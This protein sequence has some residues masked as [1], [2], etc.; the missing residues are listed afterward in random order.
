MVQTV[1]HS[2]RLRNLL[3][4]APVH[5]VLSVSAFFICFPLIWM[6]LTSLKPIEQVFLYPPQVFPK[7]VMWRNYVDA[8]TYRPFHLFFRNTM[9]IEVAVVI[10][11]LLSNSLVAYGFARLRFPGREALFTIVLSTMMLPAVVQL[12]P[13]FIVFSKLGWVNTYYPLTVPAFFGTPFFIFLLRQF[14]RG[15]PEELRDAAKI[16]GCSELGIWWRIMVPL[17]KHA[18]AVVAIFA[19]QNVWNDFLPPLI[20]L[21]REEMKTLALGLQAL[22]PVSEARPDYHWLMAVATTMVAPMMLL[23]AFTQQYFIEGISVAELKG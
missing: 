7:P 13:L 10:G 1:V 14:Y 6:V 19:F 16:D 11:S 12:I 8:L 22:T 23:F 4:Q 18:L 2:K 21:N 3:S 9:I 5:L 17:S 15:V 20:Y